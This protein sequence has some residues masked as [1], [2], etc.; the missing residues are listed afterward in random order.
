MKWLFCLHQKKKSSYAKVHQEN[1]EV[2]KGFFSAI[3]LCNWISRHRLSKCHFS[4]RT[5]MSNVQHGISNAQVL[6]RIPST[7]DIPCWAFDI[8]HSPCHLISQVFP[9]VNLC[10]FPPVLSC[11]FFVHL[12]V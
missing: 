9:F 11:V 5:R 10:A 12:S 7:L 6:A 8:L 3:S 4:K 2:D 1:M